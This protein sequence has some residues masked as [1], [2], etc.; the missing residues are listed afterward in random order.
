MKNRLHINI[1]CPVCLHLNEWPGSTHCALC[2]WRFIVLSTQ[3]GDVTIEQLNRIQRIRSE[4]VERYKALEENVNQQQAKIRD[5]EPIHQMLKERYEEMFP[6]YNLLAHKLEELKQANVKE[7]TSALE[8]QAAQLQHQINLLSSKYHH[9]NAPNV[10]FACVYNKQ[11]N[12]VEVE[13]RE[14]INRYKKMKQEVVFAVAFFSN[15]SASFHDADII[16]PTE[17]KR[18]EIFSKGDQLEFNLKYEPP[19]ELL[20]TKHYQVIHL[21]TNTVSEFIIL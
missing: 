13:V 2:G 5:M 7:D 8:S 4:T 11:T 12:Q 1:A 17:S 14:V 3:P 9:V 6:D 16:I 19:E 20:K 21:I 15:H 18:I 10:T